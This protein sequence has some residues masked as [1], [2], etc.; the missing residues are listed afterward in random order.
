LKRGR[1]EFGDAITDRLL[2]AVAE[3]NHRDHR[4][5][6]DHDPEHREGRPQEVGPQRGKRDADDL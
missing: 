2:R 1:A 4:R 3:R 5:D 6:A